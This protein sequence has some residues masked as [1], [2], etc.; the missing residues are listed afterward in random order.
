LMEIIDLS[1]NYGRGSIDGCRSLDVI[2]RW[3]KRRGDGQHCD[4]YDDDDYDTEENFLDHRFF[5]FS[6][7]LLERPHLSERLHQS[8]NLARPNLT[9]GQLESEP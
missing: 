1:E 8:S 3:L 2:M 6:Q 9:I 4:Q 7:G 5:T